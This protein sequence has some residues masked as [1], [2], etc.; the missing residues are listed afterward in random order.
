MPVKKTMRKI[1]AFLLS[2]ILLANIN[3]FAATSIENYDGVISVAEYYQGWATIAGRVPVPQSEITIEVLDKDESFSEITDSSSSAQLSKLVHI[4]QV[5]TEADGTFKISWE[6]PRA[7][8]GVYPVRVYSAVENR[9]Y[10]SQLKIGEAK[11]ALYQTNHWY[12]GEDGDKDALNSAYLVIETK[13]SESEGSAR[14]ISI[15]AAKYDKET[16]ELHSVHQEGAKAFGNADTTITVRVPLSSQSY[17]VKV[18]V[19]DDFHSIRSLG[20]STEIVTNAM[21]AP[22]G[23]QI[24][25]D[26]MAYLGEEHVHPRVLASQEQ[27]DAILDKVENNAVMKKEYQEFQSLLSYYNRRGD[28]TYNLSDGIRLLS[29]SRE[30]A[31]RVMAYGMAYKLTGNEQ[32]AKNAWRQLDICMNFDDWNPNHFLDVAEMAFGFAV[33]YDWLY[34]WLSDEQ[35]LAMALAVEKFAFEPIMEDYL[36]TERQ[37]TYYWSLPDKT[38]NWNLVCNGGV[39]TAAIAFMDVPEVAESAKQVLTYGMKNIQQGI[40]LYRTTGEWEEGVTYWCYASKYLGHLMSTLE[41]ATNTKYGYTDVE[42]IKESLNWILSMQGSTTPFNFGETEDTLENQVSVY[43]FGHEYGD[44]RMTKYARSLMQNY[45]YGLEYELLYYD[46][47]YENAEIEYPMDFFGEKL[48]TVTMRNSNNDTFVG[49]H[50]G[51]N[52]ISHAQLDAGQFIIDSQEERFVKDL[53]KETYDLSKWQCYRNRAEGHN[54]LV[55]NPTSGNDQFIG[56]DCSLVDYGRVGDTSYAIG[57]LTTA[58]IDHANSIN[59]GVMLTDNRQVVIVRDEI[60]LN[61]TSEL[62]WFAHTD[63]SVTISADKKSAILEINGKYMQAKILEGSNAEFEVMD[64]KPLST[65]PV[66]E[67]QSSNSGC[68]LAIH[69]TGFT[70]GTIEVGFAPISSVEAQYEFTSPGSL[71]TWGDAE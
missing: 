19:W 37:R 62:Y 61:K 45:K 28:L 48:A 35:K 31:S 20:K 53:G 63:A 7:Q 17:R 10:T 55:I 51:K 21:K 36:D 65:S 39:M 41:A 22:S 60:S 27:F 26:M 59:R 58:Y 24:Y 5:T 32:W 13:V 40:N 12:E 42:G 49:F 44:E 56:A 25:E 6:F 18:F 68:K 33:G 16:G 43:W 46:G 47:N 3:V 1:F 69:L 54:T 38:N 57:D 2:F 9:T 70:Q 66:L 29:T 14:D 15:I 8:E 23:E 50:N 11:V 34:D 30:L 4:Q 71:G 52:N 67:G 64:P